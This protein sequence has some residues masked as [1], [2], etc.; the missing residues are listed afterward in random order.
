[1]I[2]R[3]DTVEG[4]GR[5]QARRAPYWQKLSTGCH[6]GLRKLATN[7]EGTW[8]AQ[9]Y[10]AATQKQTRRSLGTF[11]E[12]S[13]HL[14]FDAA[15]KAAEAWFEHLGRG[16]SL[17]TLTV[18]EACEEYVASVRTKGREATAVDIAARFK[19]RVYTE[20]IADI[21][22]PKLTRK[23]I[24]AWRSKLTAIPVVVNPHAKKPKTRVRAL[25]TVNRDMAALRA[26]LNLAHDNGAVTSDMAWRV[27]LRRIENADGRRDAYL[28]RAQRS[29][30]IANSPPDLALFL[31][32]LSVI[33]LR[34]GAL[35][36]LKAA[37]FEKR[38]SVLTIGKDKTGGDRRIKLPKQTSTFFGAQAMNKL[39]SA[40][41]LARGDGKPWDKDSWKK[42]VRAAAKAAGLSDDITAYAMRH[43]TITDLVTGGLDLLTVAQ[44]SGTSVAMIEKHYGHL[45]AEHAAAALAALAL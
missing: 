37:S 31:Q 29:A 26:A 17:D 23:H 20:K 2:R 43:S 21:D 38:L 16:G 30:L 15:K 44:V 22:L 40:P 5:L 41:L 1:M 3:L 10:D 45:R 27:A 13:A 25:S 7:S 19:R 6:V 32:G 12:L 36:S 9:A 11:G 14:R 18:R 42:P 35:A 33:P 28:D 8:I 34:P 24:E 4:R 39:P